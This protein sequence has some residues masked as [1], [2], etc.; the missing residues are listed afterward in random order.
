[1][2]VVPFI[3]AHLEVIA[4]QEEQA[5]LRDLLSERY[6][7]ALL[8]GPAYTA[9]DGEDVL[10]CAGV[11]RITYNRYQAWA[12]VGQ[13]VGKN[14]LPITRE[15]KSFFERADIPRVEATVLM[16]FDNGHRWA[17]MLG[18]KNETPNGMER[19]GDDDQNYCLYSRVK[20]CQH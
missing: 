17:E 3:P 11:V 4:L 10:A 7:D 12:I 5:Y 16:S 18:F 6:T 20:K 8:A 15:I 13:N 1:M 2:I 9:V 19:Y 14:L